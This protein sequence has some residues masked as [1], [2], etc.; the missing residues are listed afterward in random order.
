M[1]YIHVGFLQQVKIEMTRK[2]FPLVFI[3]LLAACGGQ[4]PFSG[5]PQPQAAGEPTTTQETEPIVLGAIYSITGGQAGLDIPSAQGAQLA[6]DQA[7]E[8]GGILG[9]PVQLILQD[10]ATDPQVI[11]QRSQTIMD[12]YPTVTALFGLSDTDLVEAAAGAAAAQGRLFLTSGATS[13]KLPA[14]EPGYLFLAC[15]GDNVQAAAGAEWAFNELSARSAAVLYREGSTYT[16]LLQGYFQTRF[17]ELGGEI[18]DVQSYEFG[19]DSQNGG[20]EAAV[21]Q[22]ETADL[23]YLAATPDDAL[24]AVLALRAAGFE[25]PILGGD[26]L[27]VATLWQNPNVS[28]LFFTTHAYLGENNPDP[29][30]T[31]F[32]E[33]YLAAFPDSAPD[34]FAALGYDAARLLMARSR[35][36]EAPTHS[37]CAMPWLRCR[38]S[39]E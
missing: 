21:E 8:E 5:T 24:P 22:L 20:I 7:N 30:V 2:I 13:P 14:A 1:V 39:K 16:D 34:A 38:I 12:E 32:R 3:L 23:I 29:R 10:G 9:R 35:P 11:G 15:F 19:Q 6:V 28:Q 37:W 36:Q 27:D 4:L 17:T 33:A 26:G 18:V 31:A 25:Q